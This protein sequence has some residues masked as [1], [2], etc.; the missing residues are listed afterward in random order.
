MSS[1]KNHP[2]FTQGRIIKQCLLRDGYYTLT[3][4]APDIAQTA[5]PG[6]FVM[7][8][9]WQLKDL[10]LKR[11]FSFSQIESC[12]GTFNIL[13]Q[14][15]GRGTQILAESRIGDN[16]ELIGP[17]GNGFYGSKNIH[18][19]A[20]IARGIGLAPM[21]PLAQESRKKGIE[22][23]S[24]LS[25]SSKDLLIYG[26]DIE[27]I[28]K[29]TF[30]TTDDGSKGTTG[31]VTHFLEKVLKEKKIDIDAVYLCGSKRLARHTRE[32]QKKYHFHAYVSLEERMGC[33]IGSCKGCVIKTVNGY[34]RVCKEGPIFALEEVVDDES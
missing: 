24:F 33:G 17:L 4:E 1:K 8:S 20:I 29:E 2:I 30:Y 14:K 26:D 9:R 12:F 7:L 13:F 23:Y 22:I 11:P 27:S 28:S 3:I 25:A 5:K 6:Q 19:L 34:Q 16:V 10:L 32:L 21:I 18:K 31:M 15:V